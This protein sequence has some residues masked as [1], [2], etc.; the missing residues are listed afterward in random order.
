MKLN[1]LVKMRKPNSYIYKCIYIYTVR[2]V[3]TVPLGSEDKV[4]DPEAVG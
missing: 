1:E 4:F 2:S 3:L